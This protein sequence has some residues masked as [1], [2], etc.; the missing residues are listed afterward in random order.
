M[1]NNCNLSKQSKECKGCMYENQCDFIK[2]RLNETKESINF[3]EE[4]K[5]LIYA[6]LMSYGNKLSEIIKDIP[7]ELLAT[8]EL[9]QKATMSWNLAKRI[10][11]K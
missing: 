1:A 4:E 2:C 8:D 6:A 11:E 10:R 3:N 7:N 5:A 9:S